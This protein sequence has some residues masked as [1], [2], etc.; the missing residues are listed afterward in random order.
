VHNDGLELSFSNVLVVLIGL[1]VAWWMARAPRSLLKLM[2][3][4]LPGLDKD[5]PWL[6]WIVRWWGRFTFFSLL[7]AF[8]MI[9]TPESYEHNLGVRLFILFLAAAFSVF[10][11]KRPKK[12]EKEEDSYA[13][14]LGPRV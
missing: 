3:M 12:K 7:S 5:R 2:S 4:R 10:A 8:L 14:M 11:L 13:A 9:G 6:N 1:A